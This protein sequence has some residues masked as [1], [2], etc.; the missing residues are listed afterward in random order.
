L[1]F[2]KDFIIELMGAFIWVYLEF[3]GLGK[4]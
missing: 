3:N 1:F 2:R 4:N